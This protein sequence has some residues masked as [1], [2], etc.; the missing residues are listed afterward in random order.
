MRVGKD[1]TLGI[2]KD[3]A[4]CINEATGG[5]VMMGFSDGW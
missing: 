3:S 2:G 1:E 5:S 4:V